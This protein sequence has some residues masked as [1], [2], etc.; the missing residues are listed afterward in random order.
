[1]LNRYLSHVGQEG[2]MTVRRDR[3]QRHRVP[4]KAEPEI[5]D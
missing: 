4:L 1:M 2:V 5:V 3:K